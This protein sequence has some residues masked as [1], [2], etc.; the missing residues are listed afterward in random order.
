MADTDL[1]GA[2]FEDCALTDADAHAGLVVSF[3]RLEDARFSRSDLSFA[4]FERSDAYDLRVEDC[5]LRGARIQQVDF[6]KSL[7]RRVLRTSGA[8]RRC[9]FHLAEMADVSLR[10]WDLS[11]SRFREADLSGA[12]LE[13]ADLSGCD[14]FGAILSRARL[15]GAD[16]RRAEI[17]GLDLTALATRAGLKI[18]AGQQHLLLAALGIDVSL[19]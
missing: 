2:V 18:T 13:G 19:D 17:A 9:N 4:R 11:G 5:N 7:G 3:S 1:R 16:L 14:L 10:G 6:S 12:D 15:A 8:F